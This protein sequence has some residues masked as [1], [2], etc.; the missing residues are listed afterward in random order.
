MQNEC[1]LIDDYK[2]GQNDYGNTSSYEIYNLKSINDSF[3]IA[4]PSNKEE[5]IVKI[6]KYNFSNNRIE[7]LLSLNNL[8]QVMKI[9]YFYEPISKKEYLFIQM[10]RS[11]VIFLIKN[12]KEYILIKDYRKGLGGILSIFTKYFLAYPISDFIICFNQYNNKSYLII[13]MYKNVGCMMKENE[14]HIFNFQN[15]S[16]ILNKAFIYQSKYLTSFCLIYND[17][18]KRSLNLMLNLK[19]N[20][21][22][23][24]ELKDGITNIENI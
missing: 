14:I 11:L 10:K 12:E 23:I 6:C 18:Y 7:L 1:I 15:D 13:A 22:K 8:D 3:F 2:L 20:I 24:L 19:E 17:K 4:Y 5:G 9:K 16:L 21:L